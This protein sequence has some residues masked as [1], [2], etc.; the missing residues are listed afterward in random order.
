MRISRQTFYVSSFYTDPFYTSPCSNSNLTPDFPT[1]YPQIDQWGL[2][3]DTSA[4]FRDDTEP[5]PAGFISIVQVTGCRV[6]GAQDFQ[7]VED[8]VRC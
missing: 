1:L 7:A 2:R 8:F 4:R 3:S 5:L 6:S